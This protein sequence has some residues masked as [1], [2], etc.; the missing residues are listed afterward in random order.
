MLA[1]HAEAQGPYPEFLYHEG[2]DGDGLAVNAIKGGGLVSVSSSAASWSDN[3]EAV[4]DNGGVGATERAIMYSANNFQSDTGFRLH[5]HYETDSIDT[6]GSH[7]LSFG[8]VSSDTNLANYSGLNPFQAEP[9][10]YS[11][12]ANLTSQGG[13]SFRGLNFSDGSS[14]VTLDT[15][16]TRHQF[17][18]GETTKVTI[19]IN[20][21]GYWCYRI[22]DEYEA[23]GAL[24]FDF[25]LTKN[26]HIVVY[27]QDD[28]GKSIQ[29][30]TL[31]KGYA[32][33]ERAA[34]LRGSWNCGQGDYDFLKDLLTV[35]STLA[36]LNEGSVVSAEHNAPHR[37]LE[38]IAEGLSSVGGAPI[39]SPVPETWGDFNHDEPDSDPFMADLSGIRNAQLGAKFYSNSDNFTGSNTEDY[40][41][42]RG[43]LV[44]LLRYE[45]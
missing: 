26:Y 41:A 36:R 33:G 6:I 1:A 20:Y 2:F 43:A 32:Q 30:I 21:G 17:V 10:V 3:G 22:N 35:A 9:S 4:Y 11:I 14:V 37:L 42:L 25:D 19:E 15:S 28:A 18:A 40:S 31:E 5:V 7:N 38:M 24:P 23:S 16:G 44:R 29:S 39:T 34:G 45:S 13:A 27:G 8:L 12:G